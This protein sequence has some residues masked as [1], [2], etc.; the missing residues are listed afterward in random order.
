MRIGAYVSLLLR[1]KPQIVILCP[2]V[3]CNASLR[4]LGSVNFQYPSAAPSALGLKFQ[5]INLS[6]WYNSPPELGKKWSTTHLHY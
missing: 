4:A 3:R 2:T 6:N 5:I 1:Q